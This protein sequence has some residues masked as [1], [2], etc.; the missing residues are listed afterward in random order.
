M[1]LGITLSKRKSLKRALYIRVFIANL[2][3]LILVFATIG[4]GIRK[5]A[6]DQV[7][8]QLRE[9]RETFVRTSPFNNEFAQ[10]NF[11]RIRPPQN[12]EF[13]LYSKSGKLIASTYITNKNQSPPLTFT[14]SELKKF[15]TTDIIDSPKVLRKHPYRTSIIKTRDGAYLQISYWIKPIIDNIALINNFL[16]LIGLLSLFLMTLVIRLFLSKIVYSLE[17]LS[18]L[19]SKA[20]TR[21]IDLNQE[22]LPE[23]SEL[24][25]VHQRYVELI[26]KVNSEILRRE[27]LEDSLKK[28]NSNLSHEIKTPLSVIL[29]NA[30]LIKF[31]QFSSAEKIEALSIIES[32]VNKISRLTEFLLSLSNGDLDSYK[33]RSISAAELRQLIHIN[34]SQSAQAERISISVGEEISSCRGNLDLIDLILTNL[35]Q[36]A[37]KHTSGPVEVKFEV[38]DEVGPRI[39]V[40]DSGPAISEVDRDRIFERLV[41]VDSSRSGSGFGLGL[42]LSRTFAELQGGNLTLSIQDSGNS[43]VLTLQPFEPPPKR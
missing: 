34:V 6:V 10:S 19:T 27:N 18:E 33:M 38:L 11:T 42:P 8:S 21:E 32:E 24:A 5:L 40:T 3:I 9:I 25:D 20:F 35:I 23:F 15:S 31:D 30:G 28:F 4:F 36:N 29:A 22:R 14:I 13:T 43:F 7:D 12:F 26:E 37:I 2:I 17:R 1:G 16:L 41:K 39:T